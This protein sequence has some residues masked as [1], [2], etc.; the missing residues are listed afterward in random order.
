MSTNVF[1]FQSRL[2]LKAGAK[3]ENFFLIGKCFFWSFL[4]EILLSFFL[5]KTYQSFN[6]LPLFAGC[7]CN[8]QFKISQAF[9]NLFLKINSLL[10]LSIPVSLSVNVAVVAGAK[11]HPLFTFTRGFTEFLYS[12]SKLFLNILITVNLEFLIFYKF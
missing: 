8:I 9:S 10:R 11:V 1:L 4:K 3:V 2:F 6:E 7:K 12:F 5:P